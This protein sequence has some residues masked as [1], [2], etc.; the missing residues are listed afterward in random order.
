M[1]EDE[2]TD[3]LVVQLRLETDR[4]RVGTRKSVLYDLTIN[5][6][7][8]V[9]MGVDTDSG[10]PIRGRGKGFQQ[11][12]LVYEDS[13]KGHTSVVPRLIVEVKLNR[14]TSHDAIVY[15][16]KAKRI[17]HI[18]PF[19]RFGLLLAGMSSVPGR[20]LRLEEN[21]DFM[22][23]VHNPPSPDEL[24]GLRL[25]FNDEL[26]A[27]DELADILF[28]KKRVTSLRKALNVSF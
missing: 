17:K 1:T 15:S 26:R 18:Y 14:V 13:D 10:K 11:D 20:V 25:L 4:Y 5:D 6:D 16:E 21:F 23:V 28:H 27:S 24:D 9:D 19:V 7:G 22:L 3:D 12:I 8:I 2:F